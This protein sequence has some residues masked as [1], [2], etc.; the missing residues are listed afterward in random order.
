[1]TDL[2]FEE[3]D[4]L[5]CDRRYQVFLSMVAKDRQIWVLI[6]ADME[7]LKIRSEDHNLEYL[8]IWPDA[9]FTQ[10]HR[11]SS[12]QTL[13]PKAISVPEF[14]A[15]WIV[16]LERDQLKVGVFPNARE[17]VWIMEPSEVKNDLQDRFSN[18]AL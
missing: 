1:M 8:P 6:N 7:F 10:H 18:F 3:I 4:N 11:H 13:S 14:F 17:D 12:N 5:D 9:Q 15:K 2:S 16:G